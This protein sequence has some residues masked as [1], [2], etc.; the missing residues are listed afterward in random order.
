MKTVTAV[1]ITKL[2][3]FNVWKNHGLPHSIVSN[4]EPQLALQVMKDLCK[5]LGIISKLSTMH[6][7]QT[8]R[9]TEHMNQDLQ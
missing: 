2:Y 8:D 5:H 4:Q 3:L 6:H 7:P 9:Q 1:E